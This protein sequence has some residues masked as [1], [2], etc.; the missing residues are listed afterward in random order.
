MSAPPGKIHPSPKMEG[1]DAA[2]ILRLPLIQTLPAARPSFSRPRTA[3]ASL[4]TTSSL[5]SL[6]G[7][8]G[9]HS[10]RSNREGGEKVNWTSTQSF[11]G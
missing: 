8:C 11:G 1:E 10:R 3:I 7:A 2:M 5:S 9:V 4:S 6:H